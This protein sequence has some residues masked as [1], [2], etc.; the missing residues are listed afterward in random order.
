[1]AEKKRKGRRAYLDSYKKK[2]DGSYAYEGDLYVYVGSIL[3]SN[4]PGNGGLKVGIPKGNGLKKELTRLW[5]LCGAL[6]CTLLAAGCSTA[7]GP[8]SFAYVLL[9]YAANLVAC[10]SVCWG[11]G[12]LAKGGNP[13]KAHVYDASVAQIPGR[14]LACAICSGAVVMGEGIYLFQ[15]GAGGRILAVFG[16]LVLETAALILALWTRKLAVGMKWEKS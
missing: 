10:V 6:L 4:S 11:M 5:I 1:M 9:P 16:F 7:P 12:R 15:N 3:A 13:M 14:A 2:E 8:D